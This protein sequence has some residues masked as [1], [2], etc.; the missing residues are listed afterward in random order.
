MEDNKSHK[1]LVFLDAPD[2]YL[3]AKSFESVSKNPSILTKEIYKKRTGYQ[4][5]ISDKNFF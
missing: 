3:V 5:V 1:S 2:P 4:K